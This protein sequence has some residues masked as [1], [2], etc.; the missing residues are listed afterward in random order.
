MTLSARLCILLL[1]FTGVHIIYELSEILSIEIEMPGRRR[2][3]FIFTSACLLRYSCKNLPAA[4]V[5]H[6]RL[7]FRA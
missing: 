1:L 3:N 7:T 2:Y 6:E 4:A 5:D